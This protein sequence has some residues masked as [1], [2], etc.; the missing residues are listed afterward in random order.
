VRRFARA[1]LL[2]GLA[3]VGA[4]ALTRVD[5]FLRPKP[6][7]APPFVL[8]TSQEHRPAAGAGR[9]TFAAIFS[10][11]ALSLTPDERKE[12]TSVIHELA[13]RLVALQHPLFEP[14]DDES[15]STPL[16]KWFLR[17]PPSLGVAMTAARDTVCATD[18]LCVRVER[19]TCRRGWTP[20]GADE[21]G[22]RAR[23]LAW[24][25]GYAVRVRGRDPTEAS[26]VA[27]SLREA[28]RTSAR[29][30]LVLCPD[31]VAE[32]LATA[33]DLGQEWA[34]LRSLEARS[35]APT[36]SDAAAED[37]GAQFALGANEILVMPRG[38]AILDH[39]AFVNEVRGVAGTAR[40]DVPAVDAR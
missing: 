26:A 13:A 17:G 30:G 11:A 39:G 25:W 36:R 31:D 28:A 34:N 24:P 27:K 9:T 35:L 21:R 20:S 2:V 14:L 33:P 22:E 38:A 5:A 19:S 40:I 12:L 7:V 3:G 16:T 6:A 8:C 32:L 23:F 10:A 29:V 37:D 18:G 4:L 15:P 1:S